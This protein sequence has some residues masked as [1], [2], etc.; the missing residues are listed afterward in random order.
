MQPAWVIG[1]GGETVHDLCSMRIRAVGPAVPPL[2][3]RAP[4]LADDVLAESDILRGAP[5]TA[6]PRF[7]DL[8]RIAIPFEH[9]PSCSRRYFLR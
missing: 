4:T 5:G 9:R 6:A 3:C 8:N 7:G 1:A 2:T